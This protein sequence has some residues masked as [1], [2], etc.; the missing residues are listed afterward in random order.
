MTSLRSHSD[1]WDSSPGLCD[2]RACV[3]NPDLWALEHQ[4]ESSADGQVW[5]LPLVMGGTL[6]G[7]ALGFKNLGT[8]QNIPFRLLRLTA[9]S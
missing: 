7:E 3:P 4:E 1:S 8:T 5:A 2:L 6:V 9:F